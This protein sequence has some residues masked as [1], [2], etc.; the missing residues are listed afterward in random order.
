MKDIV[1]GID[2]GDKKNSVCVLDK[3]GNIVEIVDVTNTRQGMIKYFDK[4]D[5]EEVLVVIEAGTHSAWVSELIEDMGHRVLVGNPRKLRAIWA[6][7]NKTDTRDAEMLA[8]IGRFDT[9]LL[10]PIKHRSSDAQADLAMIKARDSLVRVRA[11]LVNHVRSTV[12]SMGYRIKNS[13][14]EGFHKR[15]MEAIPDELKGALE[16]LIKIIRE[17]SDEIKGYD[18]KIDLLCKEKYDETFLLRRIGGVGALTALAYVLT[19]EDPSR[20]RKSRMVGAFL[21]LVP[22]R[23][24]SGQTD[25]QLRITKAGN[26]YLRRLLVGSAQYIMGPFAKDCALRRFGMQI[27]ARG[28]KNAKRKAVI[29]VARKL[30]C[31]MHRLWTTGEIYD[32]L[33][34][35]KIEEAA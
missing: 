8:R 18:K 26:D 28:G 14:V 24:Q 20:F 22:R 12:K 4:Y 2:L 23:D 16:P 11:N 25:K 31:L 6:G 27:A 30:T 5:K 32:P 17:L 13:S 33:Y 7:E 3:N 34:K 10:Y 21:G 35:I 9:K 1:I 19:I 29:A 15:A